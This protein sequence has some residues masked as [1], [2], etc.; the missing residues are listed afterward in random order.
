[1]QEY[2]I[3]SNESLPYLELG[4]GLSFFDPYLYYYVSQTLR[5]GGE[6]HVSKT[7]DGAVSGLFI[8]EET[9]KTGAIFTQSRSDFDHFFGLRPFDVLFAELK[10]EHDAEPF[11]IYTIKFQGHAID[12]RFGHE[13]STV[14]RD[15]AQ[16][17]ERLMIAVN[18]GINKSWVRVALEDGEVCFIVKLDHE[19]AGVGWVSMTDRVGRLHSLFVKPQ[20]RRLGIGE[21]ILFAR[22]FWL[23][24]RGA[25]SAFS[26]ISRYNAASARIAVKGGMIASGLIFQYYRGEQGK[27]PESK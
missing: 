16:D 27:N 1:M 20:F 5:V 10:T 25:S 9:E 18:P 8:Y 26:E 6:A 3:V 2:S 15:S 22:L 4:K 23:R 7:A 19:I 13:V 24:S 17:I 11:D 12:H 21:D 14:D